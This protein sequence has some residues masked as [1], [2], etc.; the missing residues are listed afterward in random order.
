MIT[1]DD[2]GAFF[3]AIHG[4]KTRPFLWQ[5]ELLRHLAET[6]C[7]PEQI[8]APT[9]AGKSSVV[10]IH[11]FA[12]ALSAVG[13]ARRLPRRLTVV[14]NRRA[15]TDAHAQRADEIRRLLEEAPP[16]GGVLSRVRD[17]LAG[18]RTPDAED[19]SPLV[20]STMRGATSID[21]SWLNAPEACAVL[22]M[23]PD[24]WASSLLF[25]SYGASRG[26]RPR[27]AGLLAMDA[28]VVL[29]EA[30]LSRQVLETAQRAADLGVFSAEQ[31]G[32]PSLQVVEMTAT[33]SRIVGSSFGVKCEQLEDDEHL[34]LR[35]KA[36]KNVTYV[37]TEKWPRNGKM[38]SDYC[39]EV[40]KQV[41]EVVKRAQDLVPKGP[42]T[43][44][45]VL[46][47]VDSAVRVAQELH[48]MGLN[49]RLWVGR[50]R[51]WDLEHL[52]KQDPG[53][54][55]PEGSEEV[56]VLVATQT[57]EVGVDL[58]F[59]MIVT[60]LASGSSLVQRAGRLNR[61]GRRDGGIL[62][63]LGPLED[64]PLAKD[65]PPYRIA[66]LETG[67]SWLLDRAAAGDLPPLSVSENPPLPDMPR[68]LLWQRPEPWDLALWS[69]TSMDL[70]VEPQLDLWIRDD[71]E[72]EVGV[73]GIVLRN[74]ASLPDVVSCE[75]L[76][77]AVP[78][79]GHEVFPVRMR[80]ARKLLE[81]LVGEGEESLDLS[82]LWRDGSV[83][84]NWLRDFTDDPATAL[85]LR[86]GDLL[87][88][89]ADTAA[90]TAGV[91]TADGKECCQPVP[92]ADLGVEVV[93]DAEVL[94]GLVGLDEDQLKER[95]AGR[96]FEFPPGWNGAEPLSWLVL[97]DLVQIDDES[98][99]RS[100]WSRAER[101]NLQAHNDAVAQRTED[102]VASIGMEGT[103]A[104]ESL[105]RAAQWHDVGKADRRFQQLLGRR[106]TDTELFAKG[107]VRTIRSIRRAWADAGLPPGWRHEL[108][109]AAAYWQATDD[110]GTDSETRDLITRLIGT[111]HGRGRPLFDHDPETAG[112]EYTEA[113]EEL[114]GEG[115]W[116]SLIARTDRQWG[117]WGTAYL[118]ALLRAADCSV[119][120]E[121]K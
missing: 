108:A 116:E 91:V 3:E 107:G 70:V 48:E 82:V 77:A 76:V 105:V 4:R 84:R 51:P 12:T 19:R 37:P 53:L 87:I 114:L 99:E 85:V 80:D 59:A 23:T 90:F 74:L 10:E 25:R 52:K 40:V 79:Q 109:S 67:R 27:L 121:G 66:D 20:V 22:C 120:A 31:V 95:F 65:A 11:I 35:V 32:V 47:R 103:S 89:D 92:D 5:A 98:D 42:R 101:V 112:P 21:R 93:T 119:S 102:L 61:L 63:V 49:C 94:D 58:D 86:P 41:R 8:I 18:L 34:A 38:T 97:R 26:A 13:E 118:E 50:M 28:V 6:G 104:A 110:D 75:D 115:E 71:L 1:I 14:V 16:D 56:D 7:W 78:P 62:V 68:R 45:C 73:I 46:N 30:H 57:V 2:F 106:D 60:E 9:G 72:P 81:R 113:L 36:A 15:L 44:G 64:E 111:S 54:F 69:K 100:S 29:D 96:L 83:C 17:A 55:S 117:P 88:L 43:V 24:M 39:S 33:P